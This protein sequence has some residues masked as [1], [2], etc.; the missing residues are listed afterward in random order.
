[1]IFE[2]MDNLQKAQALEHAAMLIAHQD[3]QAMRS[4]IVWHQRHQEQIAAMLAEAKKRREQHAEEMQ[5]ALANVGA[6]ERKS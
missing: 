6:L 3:E 1:M 4:A 5:V 2:D